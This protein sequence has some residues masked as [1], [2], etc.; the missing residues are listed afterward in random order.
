MKKLLHL[1]QH[2]AFVVAM[3]LILQLTFFGQLKVNNFN[4]TKTFNIGLNEGSKSFTQSNIFN[5]MLGYNIK[6][7]LDYA[8]LQTKYDN[9]PD[10]HSAI[11]ANSVGKTDIKPDLNHYGE[12]YDINN[13]NINYF[14][15][16]LI[17][18]QSSNFNN[19]G[20][21]E[22]KDDS[23]NKD[24]IL[25]KNNILDKSGVYLYY[26]S[27]KDVYETNSLITE[28]TVLK[29]IQNSDLKNANDIVLIVGL[30]KELAAID[31]NYKEA[32][33]TY[34]AYT[35]AI[36]IKLIIIVVSLFIYLVCLVLLS[37][38]EGRAYDKEA[39]RRYY[40]LKVT[41]EIAIELRIILFGLF[42]TP[43][44]LLEDL[45]W[46]KIYS[47]LMPMYLNSFW[48]L[49][50]IVAVVLLI[51]S[52]LISFFYYGLVRRIKAHAIWKTS[53]LCRLITYIGSLINEAGKNL[54]S[55]VKSLVIS[56][57]LLFATLCALIIDYKGYLVCAL[58]ALILYAVICFVLIYRD[59]KE[60]DILLKSLKDIA[61]GDVDVKTEPENMH[62][63]NSTW[64]NEI[65][66]IG[67][68]VKKAV[69]T[70]MKDEKMKTDL[71]TNV[72]HDLKTPLTSIINYVDLLKKENIN[73]D[74]ALEYIAILDEKSQRLKQM[75][76]DLVEASKIS[77]GNMVLNIE[78][79]DLKELL[80]QLTGEFSDKFDE[81]GLTVVGNAPEGAVNIMADSRSIFRV[82]ENLFN[83][84]YK[85]AMPNTRVF[86]SIA[87][88]EDRAYLEIKN[89]SAAPINVAP[90][91][92]LER[93]VQGDESR[94]SEGSG[95]GLSI[96]KNLTLAMNGTF[97]L[98]I[99][100]DM[101][102]ALMSFEL[103]K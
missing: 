75:T 49:T 18:G 96:A 17:E 78:K 101:F 21:M 77:S 39:K 57:I 98:N 27:S 36:Y 85:Y 14:L 72:S 65:N 8:A 20:M 102:K 41:D 31:D 38:L 61:K 22:S 59:F 103:S 12:L 81:K 88:N 94:K 54:S 34:S 23:L 76:D 89:I 10:L 45:E 4:G 58:A 32:A 7:I 63:D 43:F 15:Q 71:I 69:A 42:L 30:N 44:A 46:S 95:L 40:K 29:L 24:K 99:D 62:F 100:G 90:E 91:D 67:D 68:A 97:E 60:K 26:D 47:L 50:G 83:N 51:I 74:R 9:D 11:S 53:Y 87:V 19:I 55:L 48:E 84:I 73:N 80:I 35:E 33:I 86:V 66:N 13:T 37:V 5:E 1:I 25:A 64:A 56:G 70:S 82:V 79:L 2:I 92:L 3:L 16:T 93:F 28:N 6:D 52:L